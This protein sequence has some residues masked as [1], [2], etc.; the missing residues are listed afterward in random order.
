[1]HS[2]APPQ[3][4]V[5]APKGCKACAAAGSGFVHDPLAPRVEL[6]GRF[7]GLSE[8]ISEVVMRAYKWNLDLERLDHVTDEEVATLHMLHAIMVLRVI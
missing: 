3:T 6:A 7:T 2:N 5:R 1:M 8:E 4:E